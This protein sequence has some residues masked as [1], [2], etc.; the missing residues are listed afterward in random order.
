[1]GMETIGITTK[2]GINAGCINFTH[3]AVQWK[4][5]LAN[6]PHF[7]TPFGQYCLRV[8]V[9][10]TVIWHFYYRSHLVRQKQRVQEIARPGAQLR[11]ERCLESS[12]NITRRP[13]DSSFMA[14]ST[15][16]K[17]TDED[18]VILRRTPK[19]AD[20]CQGSRKRA[21]D[22]SIIYHIYLRVQGPES[23]SLQSPVLLLDY[24][25]K[26]LHVQC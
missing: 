13:C 22:V 19:S 25:V 10:I 21:E 3:L 11:Q 24:A 2:K 12:Q 14:H 26:W 20:E 6:W 8:A 16:W 1:M 7:C 4:Y 5:T 23:S 9:I 18:S 15:K 17:K